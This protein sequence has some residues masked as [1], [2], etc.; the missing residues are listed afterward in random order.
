MTPKT[1]INRAFLDFM[2]FKLG[3]QSGLELVCEN[4]SKVKNVVGLS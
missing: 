1:R 2:I 4:L 3:T